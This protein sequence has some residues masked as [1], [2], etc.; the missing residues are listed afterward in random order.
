VVYIPN[1]PSL[2][3]FTADGFVDTYYAQS[4]IQGDEVVPFW[5]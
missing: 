1:L 3:P 2:L 4:T 5:I